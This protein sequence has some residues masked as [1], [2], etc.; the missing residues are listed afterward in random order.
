MYIY[1]SHL[2]KGVKTGGGGRDSVRERDR[3]GERQ[4]ERAGQRRRETV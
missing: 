1:I 3:E 2:P 4:C